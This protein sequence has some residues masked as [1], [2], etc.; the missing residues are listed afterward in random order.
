MYLKMSLTLSIA[1]HL[2]LFGSL[3]HIRT[4]PLQTAHQIPQLGELGKQHHDLQPFVVRRSRDTAGE[5]GAARHRLGDSGLRTD[6]RTLATFN[7]ID[8]AYLPSQRH[9]S[10]YT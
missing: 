10:A 6:C 5:H 1:I 9:L 2:L 4:L 8:H 7:M 3:E